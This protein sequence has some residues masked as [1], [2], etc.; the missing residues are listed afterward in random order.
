MG[1]KPIQ[2]GRREGNTFIGESEGEPEN[3]ATLEEALQSLAQAVVAEGLVTS[4]DGVS[5]EIV[6]HQ[7]VI[8]NQHVKTNR[9]IAT[10]SG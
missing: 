1:K 7:V 2:R 3:D 6:R 4:E 10:P 9:I 5:F 8:G